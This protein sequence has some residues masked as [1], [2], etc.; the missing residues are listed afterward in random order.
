MKLLFSTSLALCLSLSQLFAQFH[1]NYDSYFRDYA[2]SMDYQV[3]DDYIVSS[4]NIGQGSQGM[5]ASI[6]KID[7]NGNMLW[8]KAYHNVHLFNAVRYMGNQSEFMAAGVSSGK[9]LLMGF[10]K[11]GH[12]IYAF[13]YFKGHYLDNTSFDF[14]Q[15]TK[16]RGGNEMIIL[17]TFQE[18][19]SSKKNLLVALADYSGNILK[20]TEIASD[21]NVRGNWIEPL[22][23]GGY[24]I[25]GTIEDGCSHGNRGDVNILVTKLDNNLEVV[26]SKVLQGTKRF[27]ETNSNIAHCIKETREGDLVLTGYSNQFVTTAY[28][29]LIFVARLNRHGNPYWVSSYGPYPVS[30]GTSSLVI[31]DNGDG[32]HYMVSG[33]VYSA[34]ASSGW[35]AI[36]LGVKETGSL[37]SAYTYGMPLHFIQAGKDL[38][39][40]NSD[41][42]SFIGHSIINS[43]Y[44]LHLFQTDRVGRMRG[45]ENEPRIDVTEHRFEVCNVELEYRR[46]T[47][48]KVSA[49]LQSSSLSFNQSGCGLAT[50]GRMEENNDN[51]SGEMS[52]NAYPNPTQEELKVILPF[53]ANMIEIL[54]LSGKS[55][56]QKLGAFTEKEMTIDVEE[57]SEGIYLLQIHNTKGDIESLRFIKN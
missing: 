12:E 19:G 28:A 20:S 23:D 40:S 56:I 11:T 49:S 13:N 54:D 42:L 1:A 37:T 27:E 6:L 57:L 3:S 29:D 31:N 38:N 47:L 24:A 18:H 32:P 17:G 22:S 16:I 4:K 15:S 14:M 33:S 55:M 48:S 45:C 30:F 25:T 9:G 41:Q 2:H 53:K 7:N 51:K 52:L 36:L 34:D 43:D 46:V 8:N 26:W 5:Y 10:K 35:D 21:H 44:E 50:G 39:N